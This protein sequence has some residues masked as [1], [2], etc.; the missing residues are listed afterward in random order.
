MQAVTL[1]N[2]RNLF[3]DTVVGWYVTVAEWVLTKLT[4][5]GMHHA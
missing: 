4:G 2:A 3:L 5:I 1:T